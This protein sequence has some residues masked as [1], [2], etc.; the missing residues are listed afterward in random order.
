MLYIL[1]MLAVITVHAVLDS[2]VTLTVLFVD[3]LIAI[4]C[5]EHNSGCIKKME[6]LRSR[7]MKWDAQ[8]PAFAAA[9]GHLDAIKVTLTTNY[10]IH[11]TPSHI[12]HKLPFV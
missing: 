10:Y 12:T 5:L 8:T 1:L 9:A 4:T 3:V 7:G 11:T 6:V 2:T